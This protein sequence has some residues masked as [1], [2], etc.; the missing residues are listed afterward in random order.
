MRGICQKCKEAYEVE[1]RHWLATV[2]VPPEANDR[3]GPRS[4]L[5]RGKGC[6]NCAGTGYRGRLGIHEVLEITDDIREIISQRGTALKI[7][8]AAA[9]ERHDHPA[10]VGDPQAPGRDDDGR[11]SLRVTDASCESADKEVREWFR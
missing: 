8:E 6:E 4:T 9:Q 3:R 2:G 5:Y 7:K 11:G 10:G 1:T